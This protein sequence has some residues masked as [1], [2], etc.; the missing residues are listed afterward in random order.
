[1]ARN[2][3]VYK[4]EKPGSQW[5][6]LMKQVF[7]RGVSGNISAWSDNGGWWNFYDNQPDLNHQMAIVR[8]IVP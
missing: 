7:P 2:G 3:K 8:E 6:H 4:Y 5:G 1:M